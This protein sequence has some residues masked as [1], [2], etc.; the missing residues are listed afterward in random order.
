MKNTLYRTACALLSLC[1]TLG[2]L[3]ACAD[4]GQDDSGAGGS[5][6]TAQDSKHQTYTVTAGYDYGFHM[7]GKAVMLYSSSNLF[8]EIP[9][10]H[11]TVVAGDKFTITYDGELLIQESYPSTVVTKHLT[12]LGISS[13]KAPVIEVTYTPADS[14]NSKGSFTIND[15]EDL[16]VASPDTLEYYITDIETGEFASL[17]G[18][19]EPTVL[20]ASLEAQSPPSGKALRVMALHAVNPRAESKE[21]RP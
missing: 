7:P 19:T 21:Q 17:E 12:I 9:D 13:D 4:T 6:S 11:G 14:E 18:L 8:F 20:Y 16:S 3:C 10:S 2:A 1:L 15:A 5:T